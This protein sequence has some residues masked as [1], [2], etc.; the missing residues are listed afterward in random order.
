M[1]NNNTQGIFYIYKGSSS[2]TPLSLDHPFPKHKHAHTL[3]KYVKV[4]S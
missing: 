4:K 2:S 1:L 3:L